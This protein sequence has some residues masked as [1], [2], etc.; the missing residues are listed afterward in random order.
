MQELDAQRARH[1]KIKAD[2]RELKL[3]ILRGDHLPRPAV[4][5]AS[6]VALS[7]LTQTLRAVPDNLER[8]LNLPPE[9]VEA[10]SQQID[11]ALAEVARA[12]EAMA[13]G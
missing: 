7:L 12:F 8:T 11:K 3:S 6:S 5:Q 13:N 9:A 10:V 1:E 4:Q 2:E